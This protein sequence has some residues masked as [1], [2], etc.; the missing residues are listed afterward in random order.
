MGGCWYMMALRYSMAWVQGWRFSQ[1]R[2]MIWLKKCLW[3]PVPMQRN[4]LAFLFN[5]HTE[6]TEVLCKYMQ[7]LGKLWKCYMLMK[8][9]LLVLCYRREL[10]WKTFLCDDW[11]S[12]T[13]HRNVQLGVEEKKLFLRALHHNNRAGIVDDAIAHLPRWADSAFNNLSLRNCTI[14]R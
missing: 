1:H 14:S 10:L 8:A 7:A 5:R 6:P 9:K 11:G 3:M 2:K 4:N 12:F 13:P